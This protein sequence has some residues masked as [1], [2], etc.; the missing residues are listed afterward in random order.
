MNFKFNKLYVLFFLIILNQISCK[1]EKIIKPIAEFEKKIN[2]GKIRYGN[3]LTKT[4]NIKNTSNENIKIYDIKSSC[5]CAVPKIN[6]SIILPYS[7][8]KI[9][10][11]YSPKEEDIGMVN[12]TIIIKA[13]TEPSFLVLYL[14]GEVTK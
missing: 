8:K 14:E 13:N 3:K 6:D 10:V 4:F 11:E 5:G 9:K 1:N 12:Q 2:F 7:S